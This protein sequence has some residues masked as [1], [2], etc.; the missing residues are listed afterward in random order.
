MDLSAATLARCR[1]AS[2][3]QMVANGQLMTRTVTKN[4]DGSDNVS[5]ALSGDPFKCTV[6]P[7]KGEEVPAPISLM[8]KQAY[9]LFTPYNVIPAV[10][11]KIQIDGVIY[12][13]ED[14]REPRPNRISNE[15]YLTKLS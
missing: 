3:K 14:V 2:L 1:A 6:Q 7:M 15:S 13:V 11:E 9:R 10:E 8:D 4:A 5:F 12:N